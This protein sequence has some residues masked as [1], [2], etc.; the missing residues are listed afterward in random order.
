M[1]AVLSM[2]YYPVLIVGIVYV[3]VGQHLNVPIVLKTINALLKKILM[4]AH[5]VTLVLVLNTHEQKD[6]IVRIVDGP[7]SVDDAVLSGAA[8]RSPT[9]KYCYMCGAIKIK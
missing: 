8:K 9:L 5:N 4:N 1:T 6:H 7:M 3:I 2:R